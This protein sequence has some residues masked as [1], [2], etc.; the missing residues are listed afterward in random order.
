MS[1]KATLVNRLR[2]I[3]TIPVID[4]AGLLNESNT[5]TQ[6][7][8]GLPPINEEAAKRIVELES[9]QEGVIQAL[10]TL[11]NRLLD[12][13]E[14][15]LADDDSLVLESWMDTRNAYGDTMFELLMNLHGDGCADPSRARD[16]GDEAEGWAVDEAQARACASGCG[17]EDEDEDE[18]DEE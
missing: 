2:G 18:D 16:A 6:K 5:F 11:T 8:D 13:D 10:E 1:D 3:Y 14:L 17:D 9:Q 15:S 4:G 12:G 7:F